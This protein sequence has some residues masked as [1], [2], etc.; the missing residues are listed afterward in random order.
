MKSSCLFG[1]LFLILLT[2]CQHFLISADNIPWIRANAEVLSKPRY[3]W[4]SLLHSSVPEVLCCCCCCYIFQ[5]YSSSLKVIDCFPQSE[6]SCFPQHCLQFLLLPVFFVQVCTSIWFHFNLY[7]LLW[8][9]LCSLCSSR[10]LRFWQIIQSF[11]IYFFPTRLR[12]LFLIRNKSKA[13]Q[14]NLC[15]NKKKPFMQ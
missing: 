15:L 7:L 13:K 2:Y 1:Y 5:Q 4:Q 10:D 12:V 9:A 14:I 6:L 8:T 11:S 3:Y